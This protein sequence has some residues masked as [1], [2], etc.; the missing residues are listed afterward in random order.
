[1]CVWLHVTVC[2]RLCVWD[3]VCVCMCVCDCV[4]VCVIMCVCEVG[5]GL[6]QWHAAYIP[7]W[8]QSRAMKCSL[9]V[10][11]CYFTTLSVHHSSIEPH[12]TH[13]AQWGVR[14][15]EIAEE[16]TVMHLASFPGPTRPDRSGLGIRLSCTVLMWV[17]VGGSHPNFVL[18]AVQRQTITLTPLGSSN[19]SKWSEQSCFYTVPK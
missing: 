18:G 15:H 5:T 17:P 8:P 9:P 2:V 4:H 16:R 13:T 7:T 11:Q 1:M 14:V 12:Q 19:W 6:D 10:A 3:C